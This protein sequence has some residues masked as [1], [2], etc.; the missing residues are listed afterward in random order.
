MKNILDFETAKDLKRISE[1]VSKHDVMEYSQKFNDEL[2]KFYKYCGEKPTDRQSAI[3]ILKKLKA[4]MS[5]IDDSI[6]DILVS[7]LGNDL[8]D[9]FPYQADSKILT[10][11]ELDKKYKKYRSIYFSL[12]RESYTEI[13]DDL[14]FTI[15]KGHTNTASNIISFM[16]FA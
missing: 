6:L 7:G 5:N 11:Y 1:I 10:D 14:I 3:S 13:L 15:N 12:T 16:I 8:I 2:V 4:Y 9:L